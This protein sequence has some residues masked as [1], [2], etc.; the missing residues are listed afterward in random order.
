MRW[1]WSFL[2]RPVGRSEAVVCAIGVCAGITAYVVLNDVRATTNGAQTALDATAATIGTLLAYLLLGRFWE[3]GRLRDLM[4]CGFLLLLGCSNAVFAVLPHAFGYDGNSSA[5]AAAGVLAGVAFI[6]AT[7]LPAWRWE[8]RPAYAVA[9]LVVAVIAAI[10]ISATVAVA[11]DGVGSPDTFGATPDLGL[12]LAQV[13][14]AALFAL[15]AIGSGRRA[16]EDGLLAWLTVAGV[17]AAGSRTD[18]AVSHDVGDTW[19]TAGTFLR[20]AFYAVLLVA[21]GVEIR[22]YW[23][24]VA[25]MA[26][27]EE[28]R[29]LARDLHDGLAQELAFTATQARALAE[30]SEHPTRAK[31]ITAA[32]E[33]ALDESRRAIAAL[34]R[35]LDEPFELSVAQCAEEVCDRFDA[36]L[37][38][39]VQEGVQA[40]A[41]TREALLRV[42]RE[43]VSNAARHSGADEVRVRVR[44]TDGL[45]LRVEDDG[46]GFNV[47]DIG[48]LSGRFGMV[49]MRERVQALGGTFTVV[50]RLPGGTAIEVTLP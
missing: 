37:V 30:V 16:R 20:V 27:L 7:W 22:G 34:T 10:A 47:D 50:S 48:H 36:H 43:A 41:E 25:G 38:L 15:G 28:R 8:H 9:L 13:L 3:S 2:L 26:V 46:R 39:D 19:S 49:S 24:Q 5:S 44:R 11:S 29:R 12:T 35:P 6:G 32:A 40:D 33:R 18:F 4:L 45:E 17:I 21:T 1:A 23:R 31:L 14:A 42:L